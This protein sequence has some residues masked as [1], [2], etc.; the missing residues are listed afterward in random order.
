MISRGTTRT[1][2][3]NSTLPFSFHSHRRRSITRPSRWLAG[4]TQDLNVLPGNLDAALGRQPA[5]HCGSEVHVVA[6][7][8]GAVG[9]HRTRRVREMF[10]RHG[11]GQGTV[12]NWGRFEGRVLEGLEGK[13]A[14]DSRLRERYGLGLTVAL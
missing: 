5:E 14:L 13:A 9:E 10:R 8:A 3:N 11:R 1:V 12:R 6:V 2:V 4:K 7:D